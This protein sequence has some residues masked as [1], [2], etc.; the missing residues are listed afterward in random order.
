MECVELHTDMRTPI[1][2]HKSI[3][4]PYGAGLSDRPALL[5]FQMYTTIKVFN[6]QCTSASQYEGVLKSNRLP[7]STI[8]PI[9]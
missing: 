3:F 5:N 6:C 2:T 4:H 7:A 1:C 9:T 8:F